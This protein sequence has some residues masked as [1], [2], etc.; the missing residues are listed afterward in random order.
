MPSPPLRGTSPKGRGKN[1][2]S[3]FG[4]A[5]AKR[6]RGRVPFDTIRI[7]F[8]RRGTVSNVIPFSASPMP[9]RKSYT[10]SMIAAY[11]SALNTDRTAGRHDPGLSSPDKLQSVYIKQAAKGLAS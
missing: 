4:G 9:Y 7:Q 3:P 6:L 8:F 2:G 1:L 11:Y 10:F 5:G